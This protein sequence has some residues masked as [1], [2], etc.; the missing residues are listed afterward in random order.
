MN[1]SGVRIETNRCRLIPISLDYLEIIF[2]EFTPGITY[3]MYPKSPSEIGETKA[4]IERAIDHL[5]QGTDLQTVVLD[6]QTGDFLGCAGL[7]KLHTPTP[8]L[9]IW[10]RESAHGKKLGREAV[11]GLKEWAD[12]N[13]SY[14]YLVYP[15]EKRN[16][17]SRRIP[18]AL[19]GKITR[20]FREENQ[21]GKTM[22]MLE[23][24]IYPFTRS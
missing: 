22:D 17:A 16:L 24:R 23:Y 14:E 9:G 2:R 12:K 11:F 1:L 15:V 10:I 7:H 6:K 13:L 21:S 4:F 18:E 8:E 20:K 3:Y 19:G 5:K